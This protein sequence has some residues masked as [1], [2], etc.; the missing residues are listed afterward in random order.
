MVDD[1]RERKKA[2]RRLV[3]NMFA[4]VPRE[5]RRRLDAALS[6]RIR[7][8]VGHCGAKRLLGFAPMSDEPDL[9]LFYR[10]WLAGGGEL[11]MPVW[12]GGSEMRIRGVGNLNQ[13]LRPGR[14]G[15][16][17]PVDTLPEVEPK[18]LELVITPGRV[19]SE[20]L[21]RMGR[22]SGCYDALFRDNPDLIKVGAAYDFQI[23]PELPT[24]FGDVPLDFIVTPSRIVGG[25]KSKA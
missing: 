5:D 11:A 4:L 10:G 16:L 23:F 3:V 24:Y 22:G 6:E 1:V 7:D 2:W 13:D 14:G 21:T 20:S 8:F 12:L 15:I 9:A 25:G 18:D 19:F 17:E